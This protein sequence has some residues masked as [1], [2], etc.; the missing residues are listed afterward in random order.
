MKRTAVRIEAVGLPGLAL[1][2]SHR[3]R[4]AA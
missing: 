1:L 3:D 2:R 4:T